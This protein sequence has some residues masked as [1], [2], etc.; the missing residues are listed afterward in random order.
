MNSIWYDC[1][2][3]KCFAMVSFQGLCTGCIG[4]VLLELRSLHEID[5]GTISRTFIGHGAGILFGSLCGV[6]V[7]N[8]A[9]WNIFCTL[10][11]AVTVS[12]I[13]W[14]A[15][16]TW[17]TIVLGVQGLAIGIIHTS[18]F[19]FWCLFCVYATGQSHCFWS[20]NCP[21]I[22]FIRAGGQVET[23]WTQLNNSTTVR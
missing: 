18:E 17:L 21:C 14:C 19:H 8:C 15:T 7:S 11:L 1:Q 16:V 6:L 20:S 5:V 10:V 22:P 12:C 3:T 4:P 2:L 13:P 23:F 9:G